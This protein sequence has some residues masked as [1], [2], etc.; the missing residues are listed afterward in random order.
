MSA[1]GLAWPIV[2]VE[3]WFLD[4]V[5]HRQYGETASMP[6]EVKTSRDVAPW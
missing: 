5:I 1:L 2:V 4:A 3:I 6:E